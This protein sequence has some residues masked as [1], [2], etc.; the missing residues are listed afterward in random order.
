MQLGSDSLVRQKLQMCLSCLAHGLSTTCPKCGQRAQA[1]APMKW[2]PEDHQAA[3]RRQRINVGG[4]EWLAGL[5]EPVNS[6]S[7]EE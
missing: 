7:E 6:V 5:P 1:A 3:R 4:K 2:S